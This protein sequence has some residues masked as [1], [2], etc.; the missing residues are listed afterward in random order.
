MWIKKVNDKV[1]FVKES[2]SEQRKYLF[3][4]DVNVNKESSCLSRKWIKKVFIWI[5]SESEQRKYLFE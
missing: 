5:K 1:Y 3:E 4:Y 2:E